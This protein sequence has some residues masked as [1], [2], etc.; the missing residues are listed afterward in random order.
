MG[1]CSGTGVFDE[2][3]AAL[4]LEPSKRKNAKR[5]LKTELSE[6]VKITIKA[7]II[8]LENLDWDCQQESSFWKHPLV[9]Q[10]FKEIHPEEN[11]DG[12]DD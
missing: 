6:E 12:Y 1:W 3:C 5:K 11:F 9:R 10:C 2:V 8:V 7:L 4:L